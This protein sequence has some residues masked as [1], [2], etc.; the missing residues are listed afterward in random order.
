[1]LAAFITA[2][3]GPE[4]MPA[5]AGV[6]RAAR[7]CGVILFA[8]NV[9]DTDQ[10]RRLTEAARDCV[11]DDIL[12]LIDQEGGRVRRLK[13]PHWRELPPAAA[14]GRLYTDNPA[15]ACLTAG[16][17][18]RLTAAELRAVGINTNCA[19]VLDVPVAGSHD[20][21]GDRA[22]G[23]DPRQVCDLGLAVAEG[24]MAGGV[25]P[26]IKHIPG[27]G[28]ATKDSHLDLPV[29]T[30]SRT[31]LESTD[32]AAFRRLAH[33][34]AAMTAHV[35]FE[36]IDPDL[37]AS[38]SPR[39]TAEII[40][41]AIGFDGLLMSDDLGMKALSGSIGE[42]AQA[43][44]AAGSDV[45]LVCSGDLAD[46]EAVAAVVPK[47]ESVARDRFERARAVFRQQQPFDV[48]QAEAGL[49]LALRAQA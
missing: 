30:A 13:P 10:V 38:T 22:Y 35:V 44:I 31:D 19:P 5:E 32:F 34:P 1:M 24:Y 23:A 27:H 29:V 39:V 40:R 49:A 17:T 28:R 20:I 6:L 48:A 3:A 8:R 41:G 7:P 42:R 43:V 45:A 47:L 36:A 26:V 12:V 4:L 16:L 33:L 2:L 46:S 9:R 11:G 37:P 18:A 25:L 14:Y 15:D 21:I